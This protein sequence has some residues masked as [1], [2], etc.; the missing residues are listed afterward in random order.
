MFFKIL[1][2][3][4][5]C[6]YVGLWFHRSMVLDDFYRLVKNNNAFFIYDKGYNLSIHSDSA[7]TIEDYMRR[8]RNKRMLTF[9][10]ICT[11]I[12][13]PLSFALANFNIDKEICGVIASIWWIGNICVEMIWEK[14]LHVLEDRAYLVLRQGEENVLLNSEEKPEY[15]LS[16]IIRHRNRHDQQFD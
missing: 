15:I 13:F 4:S 14:L 12:V 10:C 6:C 7:K 2:L 1:F 9:H 8:S 16:T 3:V 11:F 5:A